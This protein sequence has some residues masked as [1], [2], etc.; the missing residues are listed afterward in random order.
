MSLIHSTDYDNLDL[1]RVIAHLYQ[2]NNIVNIF[3]M[4]RINNNAKTTD[5]CVNEK[6]RPNKNIK[7]L[8]LKNMVNIDDH[9]STHDGG[10][11]PEGYFYINGDSHSGVSLFS[12]SYT[13]Y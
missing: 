11:S 3:G 6:F 5:V 12:L 1:T 13:L 4:I 8:Y 7:I 10:L 9:F 2:V